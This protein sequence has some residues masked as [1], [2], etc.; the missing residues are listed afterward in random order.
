MARRTTLLRTGLGALAIALAISVSSVGGPEAH[1]A[2]AAALEA[3]AAS[4]AGAGFENVRSYAI[5]DTV[6]VEYENRIHRDPMRALG[7]V[8]GLALE[9]LDPKDV[10]ECVFVGRGVPLI[11]V[12][13]LAGDWRE[14]LEGRMALAEFR[15]RVRVTD[16]SDVGRGERGPLRSPSWLKLDAALRPL[17]EIQ[18]GVPDDP[19][20]YGLWIAPEFTSMPF[21][22]ALLT[23]Q[24]VVQLHDEFDPFARPWRP[25]R[26]TLSYAGRLPFISL[27]TVSAGYF[28]G[29]RYGVAGE[30][31]RY[32][33]DGVVEARLSADYSGFLKF[34][35]NDVVL[36]SGLDA[37]SCVASVTHR[38]KGL[39]VITT[40]S[41][42][43]Y[44][45]ED[46][47]A[48]LEVARRFR[49]LE[50]SF[51]GVKSNEGSVAGLRF[52]LPLPAP[53]W[54]YPRRVR[55]VTVPDFPFT[56]R[57]D[58]DQ[59]GLKVNLYDD[60]ERLRQ[61][62]NPV[63]VWNNLLALRGNRP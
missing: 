49:E 59:V 36:Y 10:L 19:Y 30:V 45:Y 55:P 34:S 40:V 3:I 29:N 54:G 14:F 50:F 31:G 42:G 58:N 63:Y 57:E 25:G 20:Q 5:G 47:G 23:L 60:L 7:S 46:V 35:R 22:G 44:L 62:I 8:A 33:L 6:V 52:T 41:G 56:Y 37:W 12:A 43:R 53:N 38:W 1:A 15:P 16:G 27:G 51:F 18:L 11:V 26:N 21:P 39:D 48:E 13:S 24:G 28:P 61:R 9:H 2:E 17:A 32:F 4:V